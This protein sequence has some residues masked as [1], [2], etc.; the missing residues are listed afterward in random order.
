MWFVCE[1]DFVHQQNIKKYSYGKLF[2]YLSVF[3]FD[4]QNVT[5]I[6]AHCCGRMRVLVSNILS[7]RDF[8]YFYRYWSTHQWIYDNVVSYMVSSVACVRFYLVYMETPCHPVPWFIRWLQMFRV[9]LFAQKLMKIDVWM[10]IDFIVFDSMCTRAIPAPN[11]RSSRLFVIR[12][13]SKVN[14]GSDIY[15]VEWGI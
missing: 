2:M 15:G 9:M 3:S 7:N 5:A 1:V 12:L 4:W 11:V 8:Y 14:S 6:K 13:L 10:K